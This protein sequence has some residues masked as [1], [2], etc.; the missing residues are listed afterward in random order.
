MGENASDFFLFAAAS[1]GTFS[2]S[3][4]AGSSK[5][6]PCLSSFAI[7]SDLVPEHPLKLLHLQL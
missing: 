3:L 6:T 7:R 2:E 5:N 1:T 4:L